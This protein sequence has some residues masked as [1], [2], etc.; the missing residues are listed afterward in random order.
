M[1][2]LLGRATATD[3]HCGSA[4]T[5]GH[6]SLS[7]VGCA[8]TVWQGEAD[9]GGP[10]AAVRRRGGGA[11]GGEFAKSRLSTLPDTAPPPVAWTMAVT[12]VTVLDAIAAAVCV[13][14]ADGFPRGC[15]GR[16]ARD[17]V[18]PSSAAPG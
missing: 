13:V 10:A 1:L 18:R 12:R 16:A 17:Q 14:G 9:H 2:L 11:Q 4:L 3:A 15:P 8:T 5:L 7:L 6:A